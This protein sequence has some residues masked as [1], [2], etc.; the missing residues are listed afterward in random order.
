MQNITIKRR[1]SKKDISVNISMKRCDK[2]TKQTV[3]IS[4]KIR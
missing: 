3:N 4:T 2:T 1:N